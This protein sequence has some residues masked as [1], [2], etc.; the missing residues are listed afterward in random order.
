MAA[1]NAK[2]PVK[3]AVK[4]T[5]FVGSVKPTKKAPPKPVAKKVVKK[6]VKKAAPK[7]ARSPPP[8]AGAKKVAPKRR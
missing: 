4:S 5:R 1:A 3:T 7:K 6:V 2:T 8:R